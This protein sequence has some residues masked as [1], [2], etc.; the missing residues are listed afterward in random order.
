MTIL[1]VE[2]VMR[3]VMAAA[4][5]VIVLHHGALLAEGTPTEIVRDPRVMASYLGTARA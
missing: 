2:H 3:I 4:T 1:L 5:R